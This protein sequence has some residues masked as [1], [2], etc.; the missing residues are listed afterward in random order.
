MGKIETITIDNNSTL[1]DFIF[2]IFNKI[3]VNI[4]NN[5][6]NDNLKYGM[7]LNTTRLGIYDIFEFASSKEKRIEMVDYGVNQWIEFI[8]TIQLK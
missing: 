1:F 7:V 4:L 2:S 3:T 5:H 8:S 6:R